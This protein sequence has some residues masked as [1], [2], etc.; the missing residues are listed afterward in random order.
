MNAHDFAFTGMDAQPLPLSQFAGKPALIVNT[1]SECGLTPQYAG[2]EKLHETYGARG[3][4]VIGVPCNDFGAQEPGTEAAIK[5][6]C[7]RKYGVRFVLTH[8][9]H[10][11]GE[12]AHAFYRHARET[13]G[14][15]AVPKWNFHKYLMDGRGR[16][17]SFG[18]AIEPLAHELTGAIEKLLPKRT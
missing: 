13:L 17:Q 18:S 3:L 5:T 1:A 9:E 14:N 8:K 4:V 12:S 11:I 10:V 15:D 7:E 16:L 6:F 2:L